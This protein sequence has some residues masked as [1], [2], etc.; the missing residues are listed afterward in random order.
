MLMAHCWLC[1]R[2]LAVFRAHTCSRNQSCARQVPSPQYELCLVMILGD[3]QDSF[4]AVRDFWLFCPPVL[5]FE[6]LTSLEGA[7]E[8]NQDSLSCSQQLPV[9]Q[10]GHRT[11]GRRP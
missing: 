1:T 2:L 9:T 4:L 3:A 6:G 10:A 11:G 8:G 5:I 7:S